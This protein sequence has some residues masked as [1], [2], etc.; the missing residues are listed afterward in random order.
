MVSQLRGQ[1][2]GKN[3]YRGAIVGRIDVVVAINTQNCLCAGQKL[4]RVN[5]LG[6]AGRVSYK[7]DRS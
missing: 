2:R 1:I 6:G 5:L 7:R 4:R 3:R